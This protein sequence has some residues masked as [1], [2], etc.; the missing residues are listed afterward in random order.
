MIAEVFLHKINSEENLIV[1]G[2]V[3]SPKWD[4]QF[5]FEL[6]FG[7]TLIVD[8]TWMINIIFLKQNSDNLPSVRDQNHLVGYLRL[9]IKAPS[10]KP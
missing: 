10:N 5:F 6:I 2:H 1:R 3:G 7:K 8:S 4:D 9:P